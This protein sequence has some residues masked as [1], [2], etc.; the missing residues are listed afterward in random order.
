[1]YRDHYSVKE[2]DRIEVTTMEYQGYQLRFDHIILNLYVIY[3]LP[4]SS[5]LQ[6]CNEFASILESDV[7]QPADKTLYLGAFNVHADDS[8][9]NDTI[10][11]MDT[12]ESYNL[13]NRITFP[14]N[15]K[16]QL[17]LV[18]ED[19]TDSI[20]TRVERGFLLSDHF[21]IHTTGPDPAFCQGGVTNLDSTIP[22]LFFN[23]IFFLS[24]FFPFFKVGFQPLEPPLG[25]APDTTISILKL[26]PQEVTVQ[27]RKMKSVEQKKFNEDLKVTLQRTESV[28]GLQ[29]L[30][31]AYNSVLLSTFSCTT[32]NKKSKENTQTTV[33]QGQN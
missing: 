23:Q 17:D 16:H 19:Q 5:V 2:L 20:I 15:V 32:E 14:T 29:D 4:S 26:K 9:Y 33:V 27:F 22:N 6:F 24:S 1:M 11:F 3:H 10:T 18:M 30:V 21:F 12:L 28:D 25:S 13:K 31:T 7:S 8:Y